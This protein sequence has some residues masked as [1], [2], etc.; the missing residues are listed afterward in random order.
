MRA[1]DIVD[2]KKLPSPVKDAWEDVW[3]PTGCD[4]C[5]NACTIQVRRVNGVAV[6]VTGI[7]DAAPNYG[8]TCAKG[9]A[10]PKN[11]YNPY[12]ILKPLRRRNPEK[13]NGID[14]QWE[15]M[16]WDEALD[17]ITDQLRKVREDD[18]RKVIAASFDTHSF[19]PLRAFL[20]AYGTPNFTAGPAGY[21][22]GNGVHPVSYTVTGSLDIHP[23][24][25]RSH[26]LLMFGSNFGFVANA[27]A[28]PL[29]RELSEAREKG[30]I[31]MVVVDPNCSVAASQADEWIPIRPGTDPALAL[32]MMD[33]LINELGLYDRE[34]L[35]KYTN[36]PYLIGSDGYYVRDEATDKPL[37][38]DAQAGTAKTY[39]DPSIGEYALEGRFT[40]NG[41]QVPTAFQLFCEHI[42][43]YTP[44][45]VEEITTV[46]AETMCRL[47]REFGEAAQIGSTITIDGIEFPHRPASA[48]WY[49]G[50]AGHQHAM[51]SGLTYAMLNTVVGAV[52]VPGGLLNANAAGPFGP[53]G[54]TTFPKAG[55]DGILQAT[56]PYTHMKKPH[57]ARK[58]KAPE[59][60]ELI[61]LF[62]VT[63]YARAMVWLSLLEPDKYK[64]PYTPEVLLHC[65][66]NM[67]VNTADPEAA[68]EGLRR[69]PF[70]VSFADHHNETTAFADIVLPDAHSLE[71]LV[72]LVAN[73][74]LHHRSV[75][76][77]D[78]DWAFN[79]QQPVVE[80]AGESRYWIE[81]LYEIAERLDITRDMYATFNVLAH[82][83]GEFALDPDGK[84]TWPELCDR[85]C[86]S[87]FGEEHGLDYFKEHGHYTPGKRTSEQSYPRIFH[88]GRIPL[89]LE[90]FIRAGEDVKAVTEEL[91]IPWDTSDY[92]GFVEWK[93]CQ[94]HLET[95]EFDLWAV[96][97]KLPFSTFTFS[98][99]NSWINDLV[100]RND[101][102]LD[103]TL[104]SATAQ[105]KN[106]K[107]GDI[108]TLENSSGAK[109][110]ARLRVADT[111]HIEAI[112]VPGVYGRWLT[113]DPRLR[114]KGA[115]FNSLVDYNFDRMDKVSAA[116][117]SCVK[118]KVYK[119]GAAGQQGNGHK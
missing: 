65:R 51:L 53:K 92:Q 116:L 34:F 66:T 45:K 108:V 39:D 79:I 14:P 68:A 55:P 25:K 88:D 2:V 119:V 69:I 114:G 57:P 107:N 72:P 49:R 101:K 43:Q 87:W 98:A 12:R 47:A 36:G 28:M 61:E 86:K 50:A 37:V 13:G 26:Y 76:P 32:G 93:P 41:V 46:P 81:V 24:F 100:E 111:V 73:S 75:P 63:V 20:S 118:V 106:L 90:H 67:V 48:S 40:V 54:E 33:Q 4:M 9:N 117:D 59:T 56:N 109:V 105:K 115:H 44:E 85:W 6:K 91:G 77:P 21:F 10:A 103:V 18:P 94:S 3:I 7:P 22:C 70:M 110:T 95:G 62:P 83:E 5:Y 11:L 29:T 84:Y 58:A 112:L 17:I 1:S 19:V 64:V 35:K 102:V 38:W 113:G 96:N 31:H 97:T 104:N 99:E 27:N 89:Y 23:D 74:F 52:D 30:D 71:R 15:E 8:K 78:D 80:P 82:M 16:S 42:R 60:L